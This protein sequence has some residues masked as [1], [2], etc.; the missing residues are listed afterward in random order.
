M[1]F[2]TILDIASD[3][4]YA[5]LIPPLDGGAKL[6]GSDSSHDPFLLHLEA[7]LLLAVIRQL[8]LHMSIRDEV[9]QHQVQ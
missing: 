1:Y 9:H 6:L 8:V 2:S 4:L 5:P 3:D 7:V